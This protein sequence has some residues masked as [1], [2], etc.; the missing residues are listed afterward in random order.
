[1]P[2]ILASFGWGEWVLECHLQTWEAKDL[3]VCTGGK[4]E[5]SSTSVSMCDD[6]R[7]LGSDFH[8]IPSSKS[9]KTKYFRDQ[10]RLFEERFSALIS[11]V[12]LKLF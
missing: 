3:S 9:H 1:V 11:C 6:V 10:K 7:E 5:T 12:K 8:T 2:E 4:R